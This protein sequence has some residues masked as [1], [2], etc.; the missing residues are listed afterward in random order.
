MY[1]NTHQWDEKLRM[2]ATAL[3]INAMGKG[4]RPKVRAS[5]VKPSI[6]Y[7]KA[8]RQIYSGVA[9]DCV[10]PAGYDP[11]DI[12]V[13]QKAPVPTFGKGRRPLIGALMDRDAKPGPG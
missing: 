1:K 2:H 6:P 8:N 3:R 11:S 10:G 9:M 7:K 4:K 12:G 13:K 5:S